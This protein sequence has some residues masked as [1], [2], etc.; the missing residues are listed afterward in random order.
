MPQ[1]DWP[2][3]IA[4]LS[5]VALLVIGLAC[6]L[7]TEEMQR[8]ALRWTKAPQTGRGLRIFG[9]ITL[10]AAI[11]LTVVFAIKSYETWFI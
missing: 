3:F 8:Y 4:F 5:S 6:L 2:I 1:E 7:C 9:W 11:P 10:C